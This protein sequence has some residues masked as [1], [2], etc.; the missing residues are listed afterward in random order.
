MAL[1]NLKVGCEL[2]ITLMYPFHMDNKKSKFQT[3]FYPND[4]NFKQV[5]LPI[6]ALMNKII[7]SRKPLSEMLMS[8]FP[9]SSAL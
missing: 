5:L 6:F 3:N 9:L 2:Y 8:S 1:L 7:Y 4:H